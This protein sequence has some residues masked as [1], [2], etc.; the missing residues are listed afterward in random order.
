MKTRVEEFHPVVDTDRDL[1]VE[2]VLC[3]VFVNDENKYILLLVLFLDPY[4]LS[5]QLLNDPNW[6]LD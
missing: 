3:R 2:T 5:P 4:P 6:V 1:R